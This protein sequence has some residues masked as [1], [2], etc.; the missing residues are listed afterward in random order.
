MSIKI[1]DFAFVGHPVA[2]L[3]RAREFYEGILGLSAPEVIDGALDSDRGML[4]YTVGSGTLAITTAWTDG[5]PPEFPSR[6][7][8]L[9]VKDFEATVAHLK[10]HDVFFEHG[11]FEGPGC[12]IAVILDSDDNR[13]GIHQRKKKDH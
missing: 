7:L 6:G 2:S 8:V 5:R 12:Y 13:I 9:E 4:E 1:T 3:R 11:P 10:E